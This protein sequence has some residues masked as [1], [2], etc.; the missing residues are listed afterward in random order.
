[1]ELF[2]L[3]VGENIFSRLWK[4]HFHQSQIVVASDAAQENVRCCNIFS[5]QWREILSISR[6][7]AYSLTHLLLS[8]VEKLFWFSLH[9]L[10]LHIA[11][12]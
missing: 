9:F 11:E 8:P 6:S 1:M 2:R 3:L 4:T 5:E 7:L 10:S 12:H